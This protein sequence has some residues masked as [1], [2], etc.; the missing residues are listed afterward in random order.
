MLRQKLLNNQQT[1]TASTKADA[2]NNQQPDMEAVEYSPHF[3]GTLPICTRQPVVPLWQLFYAI[4]CRLNAELTTLS[5][6]SPQVAS[7]YNPVEYAR[8][9]HCQYLERFLTTR[10]AVLFVG[11]NPG[12]WG[13][14][15]TG[16][17][18]DSLYIEW[19]E[20][21]IDEGLMWYMCRQTF[22][23]RLVA[24]RSCETGCSS[25]DASTNHKVNW[26]HDL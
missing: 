25:A 1:D 24:S 11:M 26:L 3:N 6:C 23:S 13:M 7:V 5:F 8:G 15:Q 9:L 16:V 2:Y 21:L 19:S 17:D 18:F 12:P 10:P 20:R 14:C 4:E 22:R